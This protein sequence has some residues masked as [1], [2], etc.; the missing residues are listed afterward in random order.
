MLTKPSMRQYNMKCISNSNLPQKRVGE[1]AISAYAKAAIAKLNEIGIKTI[2][3]IPDK[4][5]PIPVN[6]H[7]DLQLLHF[8]NNIIFSHKEH[9]FK[10][11]ELPDFT[12]IKINDKPQSFYPNDVKL[13]CAI[14]G[15]KIICNKKTIAAEI[16]ELADKLN[17]KIINTNQGYA[18][19]SICIVN[20][21]AIIT[22][23]KSIFTAVGNYFDDVLFIS[24]NSIQLTGYNYGFIGGCC[25]KIDKDKIAFNGS[26]ESHTD[27][28]KIIDFL[29]RNHVECVELHKD[30]LVD[31]GGILPLME[32]E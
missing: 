20:E 3:I 21:N 22:D 32:V 1:V 24:K 16:L 18:K 17:Y 9:M 12:F 30:K 6:S 27:Y 29:K 4:R 5:L 13:N 8:G 2:E 15:N 19:C 23:D 10:E 11:N 26:I 31:I 25:G 28:K 14:I 7:T